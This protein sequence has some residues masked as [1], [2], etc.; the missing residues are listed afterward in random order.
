[1]DII[2]FHGFPIAL[3]FKNEY[4]YIRVFESFVFDPHFL[5]GLRTNW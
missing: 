4:Y 2:I 5:E 3:P 1:M